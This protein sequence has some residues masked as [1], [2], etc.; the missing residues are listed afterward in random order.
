MIGKEAVIKLSS[1][2]TPL[3][4]SSMAM[5]AIKN[6]YS[7]PARYPDGSAI[8]LRKALSNFNNIDMNN[9]ICGNGS[10]EILSMFANCFAGAGDEIIYSEHG[11]LVYPIATKAAGAT[12]IVAKEINY[13]VRMCNLQLRNNL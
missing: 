4:T 12:P 9:I 3:G 7:N 10:D 5:K 1:N 8:E 11:F 6:S 13:E 2:E